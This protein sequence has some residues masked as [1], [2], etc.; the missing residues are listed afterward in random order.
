M[1]ILTLIAMHLV[2]DF[3]WSN[4]WISEVK[5]TN[6]YILTVHS[7]LWTFAMGIGFYLIGIQLSVLEVF[8]LFVTH[9]LIDKWKCN[10][11]DKTNALTGDLY[12]DQISHMIVVMMIYWL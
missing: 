1:D 12:V 3:A 4:S 2:G 8:I 9:Y 10:L 7:G 6:N 5:A 11:K